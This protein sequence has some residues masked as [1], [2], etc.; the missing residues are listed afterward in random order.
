M[1]ARAYERSMKESGNRVVVNPF[2]AVARPGGTDK[3]S[4]SPSAR[5]GKRSSSNSSGDSDVLSQLHDSE[6][7]VASQATEIASQAV[8]IARLRSRLSVPVIDVSQEGSDT[9]VHMEMLEMLG[10]MGGDEGGA[11]GGGGGDGGGGKRQRTSSSSSSSS[12]SGCSS[13]GG[14]GDGGG[15]GALAQLHKVKKET[16]S[17]SV[18]ADALQAEKYQLEDTSL[19]ALCLDVPKCVVLL[20]GR[21]MCLCAGCSGSV[22]NGDPCPICRTP[23]ADRIETFI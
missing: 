5:V 3:G 7:K 11:A 17:Q 21:H 18:R 1:R 14:G 15:S 19:C 9:V 10:S 2:G 16:H 13:S 8:E 22:A 4:S 20:P 12:R 23:V 6:A